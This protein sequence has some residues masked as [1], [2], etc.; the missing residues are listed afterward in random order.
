MA[1]SCAPVAGVA[2]ITVQDT[3]FATL[4]LSSGSSFHHI[5]LVQAMTIISMLKLVS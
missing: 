4:S 3:V 1:C 2:G 5:V